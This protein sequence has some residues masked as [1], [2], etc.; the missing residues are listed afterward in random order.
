[1][2]GPLPEFYLTYLAERDAARA[3]AVDEFLTRL[4]DRE[5]ALMRE[6]A[7]MAYVHGRQHPRD[8]KHPKDS[9]VLA[10]VINACLAMPDLYP[11]VNAVSNDTPET[12][13]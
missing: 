6:A 9:H 12:T 8:E 5:R 3:R 11:A 2:T 7:V 4:T 13:P 10:G 1:M